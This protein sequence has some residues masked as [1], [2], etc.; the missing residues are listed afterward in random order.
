[1]DTARLSFPAGLEFVATADGGRRTPV[2][3]GY[4]P[5]FFFDGDD[6]DC[7]VVFATSNAVNPGDTA[8]AQITLS[9]N[10]SKMLAGKVK[11]A[12]SFS[13]REG[14]RVVARGSIAG[15]PSQ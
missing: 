10:A 4:R 3:S 7:E 14:S 2:W 6:Y 11:P 15:E 9:K 12:A 1:M 13:L 8:S 5:Q